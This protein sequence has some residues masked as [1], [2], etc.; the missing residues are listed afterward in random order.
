L[1][2]VL[3]VEPRGLLLLAAASARTTPWTGHEVAA[4]MAA[5]LGRPVSYCL[6]WSALVRLMH[7]PQVPRPP[8]A[9]ADLAEQEICKTS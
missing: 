1:S 4:W 2:P 5:R 3:Q 8:Q 6:C 7:T 9:L